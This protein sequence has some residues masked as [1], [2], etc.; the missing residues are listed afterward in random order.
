VDEG[1]PLTGV[2]V[3]LLLGASFVPLLFVLALLGS[4]QARESALRTELREVTALTDATLTSVAT[5]LRVT[6][7]PVGPDL[8]TG[9]DGDGTELF[10]EDIGNG[11]R[12]AVRDCGEGRWVGYGA[13]IELPD[14]DRGKALMRQTEAFWKAHDYQVHVYPDHP[15]GPYIALYSAGYVH[16]LFLPQGENEAHLSSSSDGCVPD[17]WIH[18]RRR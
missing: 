6:P 12:V 18:A 15:A 2:D 13:T 11:R 17:R 9:K 10:M 8:E 16:R 3:K 5:D 14:A 1:R 7:D 4:A